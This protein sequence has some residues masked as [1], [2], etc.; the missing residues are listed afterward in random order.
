MT[1]TVHEFLT[2][3]LTNNSYF[4]D[5]LQDMLGRLEPYFEMDYLLPRVLMASLNLEQLPVVAKTGY[6]STDI[7]L[8]SLC[9][10]VKTEKDISK[11]SLKETVR[12][13]YLSINEEGIFI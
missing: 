2:I 8:A 10:Y 4:S 12:Q 7:I 5:V 13:F 9:F 3:R 6:I 11:N 1:K